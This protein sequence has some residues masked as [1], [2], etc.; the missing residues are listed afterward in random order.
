MRLVPGLRRDP[1]QR[2]APS[3]RPGQAS[4]V[5]VMT[6]AAGLGERVCALELENARLNAALAA[7]PQEARACRARIFRAGLGERRKIERNLHD[8]A[9]QRLLALSLTIARIGE[10]LANIARH[11]R[12]STAQVTAAAAAC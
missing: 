5:P 4:G 3:Q 2:Q 8:G 10:A 7:R 1:G 6:T 11:V 12:A 9:Q